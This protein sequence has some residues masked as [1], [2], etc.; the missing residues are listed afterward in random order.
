MFLKDLLPTRPSFVF[1]TIKHYVIFLILMLLLSAS[2][3]VLSYYRLSFMAIPVSLIY[4]II[5]F[6]TPVGLTWVER[7]QCDIYPAL[8]I[9]FF[10]FA[11]YESKASAFILAA[12]FASLKL[13]IAPFFIQAFIL[14]LL[15]DFNYKKLFFFFL[16][17]AVILTTLL[18]FPQYSIAFL[19]SVFSVPFVEG[20]TLVNRMPHIVIL[21]I[22]FLSLLVYLIPLYLSPRKDLFLKTFLPYSTGLVAIGVLLPPTS[23][24]YRTICFLGFIP[25][26]IAWLNR[27]SWD[28]IYTREFISLF[29]LFLV[30][31]F[32][33]FWF[34]SAIRPAWEYFIA[35]YIAFYLAIAVISIS[36]INT[37]APH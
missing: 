35:S 36:R 19:T 28:K 23:W 37:Q 18:I 3:Y 32:H 2:Y 9:L 25:M 12:F 17:A 7:G 15:I 8:A 16:F 22:P 27:Y 26:V 21:L 10:M 29:L 31:T 11:V 5:I 34:I 20:I 13:T 33:G 30:V 1:C 4:L 14:Y 6:L 24:E